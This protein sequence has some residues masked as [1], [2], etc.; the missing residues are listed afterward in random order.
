MLYVNHP[1]LN[2]R[3]LQQFRCRFR[4]ACE[5]FLSLGEDIRN[6]PCFAQWSRSDAVG[7]KPTNIQL[8]LLGCL[9]YIG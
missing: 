3:M 1:P 4:V 5:S 2:E 7:D 8:I 9:R 6:D